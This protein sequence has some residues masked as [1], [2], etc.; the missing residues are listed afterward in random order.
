MM[1]MRPDAV[2]VGRK[3]DYRAVNVRVC[4]EC[5]FGLLQQEP[6]LYP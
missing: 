5:E 4:F 3:I 1:M 2:K 6:G